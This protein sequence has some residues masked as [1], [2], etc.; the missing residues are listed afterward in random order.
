MRHPV[1]PRDPATAAAEESAVVRAAAT[2]RPRDFQ[3]AAARVSWN[4]LQVHGDEVRLPRPYRR[5]DH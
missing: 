4:E 3:T 2:I 5:G 1:R